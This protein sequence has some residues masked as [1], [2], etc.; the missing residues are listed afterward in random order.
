MLVT[1]IEAAFFKK[2][3]QTLLFTCTDG[4]HIRAAIQQALL[5][6]EGHTFRATSVG[7]LPDG[8]EAVR[9]YITW[10]FKRKK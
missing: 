8:T 3:D 6:G 7:T 5:T 1:R 10:S 9:V 2:A 4:V